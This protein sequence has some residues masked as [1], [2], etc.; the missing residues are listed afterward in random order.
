MREAGASRGRPRRRARAARNSSD[1]PSHGRGATRG[2]RLRGGRRRR[3]HPH[4]QR[5][6]L[7]AT[8]L[9]TPRG[10]DTAAQPPPPPTCP[11]PPP[12]L[13]PPPRP[14]PVPHTTPPATSPP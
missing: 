2:R 4:G 6:P 5:P 7:H 14:A 1:R 9:A 10:T 12:P 8:A 11:P 3:G 13:P